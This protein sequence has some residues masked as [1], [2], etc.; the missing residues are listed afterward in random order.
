MKGF[1]FIQFYWVSIKSFYRLTSS[2]GEEKEGRRR[3][4]RS[5]KE[6]GSK[7][8]EEERKIRRMGLTDMRHVGWS[9]GMSDGHEAC[10]MVTGLHYHGIKSGELIPRS[11]PWTL[12]TSSGLN[13]SYVLLI[14]RH[15]HVDTSTGMLVY[16]ESCALT[17]VTDP[18]TWRSALRTVS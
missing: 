5:R 16:D 2:S 7:E 1:F 18:S 8:K 12:Q 15:A 3:G 14:F 10:R 6:E 17:S 13:F 11:V 4:K 9:W